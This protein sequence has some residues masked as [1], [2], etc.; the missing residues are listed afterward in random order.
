M[1]PSDLIIFS[2][3]SY[4]Y[5]QDEI[6]DVTNFTKGEVERKVFP[7]LERYQRIISPI[8]QRNVVL[9]G[10]TVSDTETLEIYDLACTLVANGANTL[11]VIVPFFGYSTMERA[12]KSGEIV[13]AKNRARL[14]SSIPVASN[15]NSIVMFDLHSE[16][17]P[18]YFEGFIHPYHLYGKPIIIE[19]IKEM[20]SG[21]CILGCTDAGR[22]K[23][24]ESLANDV[25]LKAAF[26]LKR[27]LDARTT[28]T[29]AVS[30]YVHDHHVIIYDDMIRTGGSLINAAKAYLD[31][32]AKE[33]SAIAT[34][35]LFPENSLE[36]IKACGYFKNLACTNSHS[37]TQEITD[38]FLKVKSISRLLIDYIKQSF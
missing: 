4:R 14:F 21:D 12:V 15:G 37:R 2:S 34:H 19:A 6:C 31:A 26:I 28:E 16:G 25:G 5:L 3:S 20:N 29:M 11:T 22:A 24:V 1:N 10:G 27:R 13:T 23:W 35:G 9:I 30:N 7:D 18:H 36:K 8:R 38:P 17:I 33:V 32:G